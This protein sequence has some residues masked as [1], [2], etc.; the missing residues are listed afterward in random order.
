MNVGAGKI[1]LQEDGT[2]FW[3]MVL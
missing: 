2:F 1:K 3:D